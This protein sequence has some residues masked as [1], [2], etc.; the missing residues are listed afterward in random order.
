MPI[1]KSAKKALRKSLKN[2][3]ENLIW[4]RKY[5]EAIKIAKKSIES[6]SKDKGNKISNA[7]SVIDKAAKH[8]IIHKNKAARLKSNLAKLAKEKKIKLEKR[9][10]AGKT[11]IKKS[12]STSK[13][14]KKLASKK[15][16][17]K[18]KKVST[19]KKIIKK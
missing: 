8:N 18:T 4:K 6:G 13:K 1:I 17:T 2:R 5:K 9:E 16:K 12:K 15:T 14:T 7:Y 10:K 11:E 3:A 19:K